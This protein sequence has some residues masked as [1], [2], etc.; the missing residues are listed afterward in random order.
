MAKANPSNVHIIF[1]KLF[2]Q[3]ILQ[4]M[5][6]PKEYAQFSDS[7]AYLWWIYMESKIPILKKS[8]LC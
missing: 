5:W 3:P 2:I 4:S 7:S 1:E 8:A 6:V